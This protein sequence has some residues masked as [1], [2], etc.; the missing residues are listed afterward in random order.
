M[1]IIESIRVVLESQA[2]HITDPPSKTKKIL[3]QVVHIGIPVGTIGG[4]GY[5]AVKG[6]KSLVKQATQQ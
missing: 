6:I 5:V 2:V 1:N 4:A 3:K